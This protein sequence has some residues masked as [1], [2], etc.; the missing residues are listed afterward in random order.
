MTGLRR[1]LDGLRPTSPDA[2][3]VRAFAATRDEAAFTQLVRRHGPLVYGVCRRVFAPAADD[4][5]QATFLLLALKAGTLRNP[6]AV[7]GWLHGVAVRTS[8]EAK[9][10]AARRRLKERLAAKP[11]ATPE[12]PDAETLALLDAAVQGLPASYR[13]AVL[14]CDL[15][16]KTRAEAAAE[17]GVPEGTV[18]SRLARGRRLLAAKLGGSLPV[19]AA[20]A[21]S[22]TLLSNTVQAGV[23]LA[24]GGAVPPAVSLLV[25][26][27]TR[28]MTG[29]VLKPVLAAGLVAVGVGGAWGWA[30][31]PRP[32]DPPKATARPETPAEQWKKLK[33]EYDAER[34]ANTKPQLDPS[35]KPIPN[36]STTTQPRPSKYADRLTALGRCDDPDVAV[37]ALTLTVVGWSQ[38]PAA[39][40]A[41]DQLLVR[42]GGD[43]RLAEFVRAH[44]QTG[45][46]GKER[47]LQRVLGVATDPTARAYATI[48]L[49]HQYDRPD[50]D[51]R[52]RAAA[53][54]LYRKVM[55]EYAGIEDGRLARWAENTLRNAE[56]MRPGLP[57]PPLAGP[58]VDGKPMDLADF[59]GRVVVLAVATPENTAWEY[60]VAWL[61]EV[62]AKYAGRPVT[63]VGLVSLRSKDT[64]EATAAAAA[65]PWRSWLDIRD[66]TTNEGPVHTTWGILTSPSV[67]VIDQRRLIRHPD[68][69]TREQVEAAVDALLAAK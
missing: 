29:S 55:T 50:A 59:R 49:A 47:R 25:S 5:F 23:L 31:V 61:K 43:P 54:A 66:A 26:G 17:L 13:A 10:M 19:V 44:R 46:T 22:P 57:A 28:A 64:P 34:K 37:A 24:A 2:E 9:A 68:L 67:I 27:A 38:L 65:M 4:A 30:T 62:H 36:L 39:D 6:A 53:V 63:V 32:A 33:A 21:V 20:V 35:G 58:A 14:L 40:D 45:Y 15:A 42:F 69:R 12:P 41:L 48:D 56:K 16:E 52:T 7:A 1:L 3:L 8:R 18:A 11:E 51:E 60:N